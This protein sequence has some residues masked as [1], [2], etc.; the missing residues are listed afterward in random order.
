MRYSRFIQHRGRGRDK[1][2]PALEIKR[3]MIRFSAQKEMCRERVGVLP[4]STM[5]SCLLGKTWS[6]RLRN[7]AY[8]ETWSA[9][10]C[11]FT[12]P[13]GNRATSCVTPHKDESGQ[14]EKH[15]F[16]LHRQH[17]A[18]LRPRKLF[19]RQRNQIA[20]ERFKRFRDWLTVRP[21][22]LSSQ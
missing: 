1:Q 4:P 10:F 19:A 5:C 20:R 21:R 17:C 15:N 6:Q 14:K 8:S 9:R 2:K 3:T 12:S 11:V 13:L 7:F 16:Y 22:A 18:R